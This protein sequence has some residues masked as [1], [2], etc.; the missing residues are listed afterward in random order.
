MM[1]D[2]LYRL[3]KMIAISH[4]YF[5]MILHYCQHNGCAILQRIYFLSVDYCPYTQKTEQYLVFAGND[6]VVRRGNGGWFDRR[7]FFS[8]NTRQP[9]CGIL[10]A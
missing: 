7:R 6:N 9:Y 5:W 8:V 1:I 4:H 2:Q 3:G 10:D